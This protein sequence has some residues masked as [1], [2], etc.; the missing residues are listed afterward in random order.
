[1]KS[2]I[3]FLLSVLIIFSARAQEPTQIKGSVIDTSAAIKLTNASISILHARDSILYQFTRAG[4][5]GNFSFDQVKPDEYI[6]LFTYPNYADYVE[7]LNVDSS[8]SVMNLGN[9]SMILK[10]QLLE[11]VLVTGA[12]AITI[13][14]DTTEYDASSFEIQPNAKVEDLLKQLPGIQVDRDGKITAQGETV[15]RVLVD[16]EEFFGDDPTLVTKNLRSDMV[17]K[18]QLYDRKSDQAAFTGID[19]GETDKTI[20]IKLKEGSN[21]GY[22][23]KIDVGGATD[24]FYQGQAMVNIFRE[25]RKF[26]AFGNMANTGKVGLAWRDNSRYG[27]EGNMS[28]TDDGAIMIMGGGGDD[29]ESFDGRYDGQ[30]IP[31]AITGGMHYDDKWDDDKQ[32]INGNYKIGTLRVEGDRSNIVQNNLPTGILNTVSNETFNNHTFRQKLDGIYEAKLDTSSTLKIMVD[33]T[34]RKS[35]TDNS[36]VSQGTNATGGLLN[37]SLRSIDN[38][39]NDRIFN[40]N[41][42]WTKKLQ[43]TGRTLSINLNQSINQSN[44]YGFLYNLI[45]R[46]EEESR[47]DS[48]TDQ[49]KDNTINTNIFRSNATYTEPISKTLSLVFNYG[50]TMNNGTADRRSINRDANGNYTVLDT[51]FSNNFKLDQYINQA[52]AILNFKKGKTVVNAGT[53]VN[54]VRFNQVDLYRNENFSQ[55]F[56]YF[57][58]QATFQYKFSQQR[59]VRFNYSGTNQ[60]PSIDQMQPIR[61]NTDGLNIVSGNPNLNPAFSNNFNLNYNS[62]RVLSGQYFSVYGNYSFTNN[63][64]V[65][66]TFTDSLG[67]S[68]FQFDNLP[69]RRPSNF[70]GAVYYNQKIKKWDL[71]IGGNL[72]TNGNIFYNIANDVENQTKAYS[73]NANLNIS[74]Y[75]QK[76]YDIYLNAGPS[77]QT[78]ES[79]LQS[80]VNNNG[81]NF[82][83][84]TGINVYLPA[85]FL[86]GSDADYTF[87]QATESFATNFERLLINASLSKMFFKE[88]NLQLRLSVNDLLNQNVGFNRT[89]SQNLITEN[90]H[91]T[92]RRYFMFSIIWD[93]N[94]MGGIKNE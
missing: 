24:G 62:Y 72:G 53:K 70:Y 51:L 85:K 25:K 60:Q 20:N 77:Y 84:Q 12:N 61:N 57:N 71:N 75:K 38:E 46:Y 13:K 15:N 40:A 44:T 4:E 37:E 93:F 35:E 39:A 47:V 26:S 30:G 68:T 34:V 90:R 31:L 22:F 48:L 10:S 76:K 18:V 49:L 65:S 89:A 94:K 43:K 9:I 14:G 8:G 50:F 78:N 28:F 66:N 79:S 69:N 59:S 1:M 92:I 81:W 91:T 16:G 56:F 58:P 17:D 86:I 52:G 67:Q 54:D 29:F 5:N 33:A 73:I 80:Q 36:Y 11:E 23:G 42:L 41:A 6:I 27:S 88:E 87:S 2:F 3:P 74:K 63:P 32:S 21:R 45:S 19:D 83:A 82:N 55:N 7:D 64:I